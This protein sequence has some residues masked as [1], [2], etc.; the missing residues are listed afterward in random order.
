MNRY[1]HGIDSKLRTH[2]LLFVINDIDMVS[3]THETK[4]K[5]SKNRI[6]FQVPFPFDDMSSVYY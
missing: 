1:A 5:S 4:K 6:V 3:H 2:C